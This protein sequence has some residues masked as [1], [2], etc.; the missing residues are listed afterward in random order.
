MGPT[1]DAHHCIVNH[2][3][4]NRDHNAYLWPS[5]ANAPMGHFGAQKKLISPLRSIR[6]HASLKDAT[7]LAGLYEVVHCTLGG[8]AIGETR[9]DAPALGTVQT[10]QTYVGGL[11]KVLEDIWTH[12]RASA[13]LLCW[14]AFLIGVV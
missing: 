14:V 10:V 12:L 9:G 7:I 2:S 3:R 5:G 13:S 1:Y 11:G 6:K 4:H 8:V